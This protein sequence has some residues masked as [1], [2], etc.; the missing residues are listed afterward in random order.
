MSYC[1]GSGC[2]NRFDARPASCTAGAPW[3]NGLAKM[4]AL[5]FLGDIF[6]GLLLGLTFS[7]KE[8]NV[9]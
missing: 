5:V 4:F 3:A 7:R 6:I 2:S 1:V 9:R 8:V